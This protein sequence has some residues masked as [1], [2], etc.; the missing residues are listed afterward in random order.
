MNPQDLQSFITAV[1]RV[2]HSTHDQYRITARVA[3]LLSAL[4][5]GGYRLPPEY[6][7]PAPDRHLNYPLHLAADDSWCLV[8]VVWN[9]GQ[10]TPVHGHE[11]W[12]VAGVY[13]GAERE[14]RYLKPGPGQSGPLTPAGEHTWHRGEVTICCTTDDDVHSVVAVGSE[15]TVGLHVYGGNLGKLDRPAYDPATGAVHW[16]VSPWDRPALEAADPHPAAR[17]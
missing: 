9:A 16:F 17:A 4:L 10:V 13:S 14:I 11:T 8:A 6:V 3:P 2:V 7:R 12:G 15:P 5:A 1:D